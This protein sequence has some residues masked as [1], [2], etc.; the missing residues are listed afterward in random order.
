MNV[1]ADFIKQ[2]KVPGT[3]TKVSRFSV[4]FMVGM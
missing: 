4:L 3:A 2:V 1:S